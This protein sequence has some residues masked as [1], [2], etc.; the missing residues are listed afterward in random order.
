MK[1]FLL[2]S[3][4]LNLRQCG[5]A[6]LS[7]QSKI[8]GACG[9]RYSFDSTRFVASNHLLLNFSI[10]A[11]E[12]FFCFFCV[13]MCSLCNFQCNICSLI[14]L[15]ICTSTVVYLQVNG[16]RILILDKSCLTIKY[17]E[18]EKLSSNDPKLNSYSFIP[19]L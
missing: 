8:K 4:F 18:E 9:A 17:Q 12:I 7:L 5:K 19:P 14:F 2:A 3:D 15:Y 6:G 16:S 11:I 13:P 10:S 1:L